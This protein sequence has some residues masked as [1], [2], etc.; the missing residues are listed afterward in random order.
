MPVEIAREPRGIFSPGRREGGEQHKKGSAEAPPE[1]VN[2]HVQIYAR[3]GTTS[4]PVT[5]APD[6]K[7]DTLSAIFLSNR[8]NMLRNYRVPLGCPRSYQ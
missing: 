2:L 8:L 3:S 5:N 4:P 7:L 1:N 6:A